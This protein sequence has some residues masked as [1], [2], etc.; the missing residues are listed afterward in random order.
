[1]AVQ[2]VFHFRV[3]ARRFSRTEAKPTALIWH[4]LQ[5][6]LAFFLCSDSEMA[7]TVG[8]MDADLRFPVLGFP[9]DGDPI[10][11][12]AIG[13]LRGKTGWL[14]ER[15]RHLGLKSSIPPAAAGP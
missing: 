5:T 9:V 15:G 14:S 3:I 11:F 10:P 7:M 4:A 8:L 2:C 6:A 12:H 13:L 1:M